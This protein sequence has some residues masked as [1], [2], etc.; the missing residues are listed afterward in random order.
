ML[1]DNIGKCNSRVILN[2][3]I[4]TSNNAIPK[5]LHVY[6]KAAVR[7]LINLD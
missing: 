3:R 4:V 1:A 6:C 7:L 5:T 2:K